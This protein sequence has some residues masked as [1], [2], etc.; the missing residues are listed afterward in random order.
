MHIR[1]RVRWFPGFGSL[2]STARR[3]V[4][5]KKR[6]CVLGAGLMVEKDDLLCAVETYVPR[7]I[8]REEWATVR[9][10][11]V[12]VARD[13]VV[14]VATSR[15]DLRNSLIAVAR[16]AHIAV[17]LGGELTYQDVFDPQIV[18]YAVAQTGTTNQVKGARR[19]LLYRLGRELNP[20]W[21]FDERFT[22]YGFKEPDAPYTVEEQNWLI[23]WAGGLST[24]Y[25]RDNALLTLALGLG[26]GLRPGEMAR[27]RE[28]DVTIHADG[29][30]TITTSGHRGAGARIVPVLAEWE[31]VI[32][33]ACRASAPGQLLLWNQRAHDTTESVA[34]IMTRL[35]KPHRVELDNRR[36]RTTW[37]VGHINNHVPE[38]VICRAAGLAHLKQFAKWRISAPMHPDQERALL[39][40]APLPTLRI[41]G[42]D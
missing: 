14:P 37:V 27:L 5:C 32:A 9:D 17:Q 20:N 33:T 36:L 42:T 29:S 6:A 24:D 12:S 38:T 13:H 7:S 15:A 21:P 1:L 30:V 19:A 39:R 22:K 11:T 40:R 23:Q 8:T 41:A 3:S 26:A 4:S 10:F 2:V 18:E 16:A 34:A 28:D 25:Q 31:H 35:G